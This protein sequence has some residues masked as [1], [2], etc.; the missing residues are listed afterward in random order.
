ML[1]ER[2]QKQSH[3]MYNFIYKKYSKQE[4]SQRIVK[5]SGCYGLAGMG[6]G[7]GVIA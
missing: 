1:T 4:N 6:G 5:I 3:I 7:W 2:S